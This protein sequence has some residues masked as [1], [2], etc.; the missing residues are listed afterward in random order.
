MI[1]MRIA[2]PELAEG[3]N[4]EWRMVSTVPARRDLAATRS[5]ARDL[6]RQMTAE[7]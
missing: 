2:C 7:D 5:G 4:A 3:R 1:R 6:A